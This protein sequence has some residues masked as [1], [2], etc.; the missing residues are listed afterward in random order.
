ML[1]SCLIQQKNW[2]YMFPL[3]N[4]VTG[5]RVRMCTLGRVSAQ[6]MYCRCDNSETMCVT[7][8]SQGEAV[9]KIVSDF[10]KGFEET[11]VISIIHC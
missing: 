6:K 11:I 9:K 7:S 4:V 5:F 2:C 8:E 1:L 10:V 3:V